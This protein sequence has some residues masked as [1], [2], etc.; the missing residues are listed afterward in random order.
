MVVSYLP[1]LEKATAGSTSTIGADV[2]MM[3]EIAGDKP[4]M[5]ESIG[6]PSSAAIGG[7]EVAQALFVETMLSAILARRQRFAYANLDM[8]YDLGLQRCAALAMKKGV[9]VDGPYA[10]F[11]CSLGLRTVSGVEKPSWPAFLESASAFASP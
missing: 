5:L 11:I 9:P 8:L 2:D 4:V 6:Y 1:G 3:V 10:A 7:T